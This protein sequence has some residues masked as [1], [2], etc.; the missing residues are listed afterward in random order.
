MPAD[1]EIAVPDQAPPGIYDETGRPRF[2]ADAGLDRLV[3]VVL[4]LTSEVW[5]LAERLDNLEQLAS[6]G[7]FVTY[8]QIKSYAPDA[9]E[10]ARRD[11]ER[12]RFVQSVLGPLREVRRAEK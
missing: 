7:G 1:E 10:T 3:S 8:E 11:A 5:V 4:Q 12:D 2:F 6:R 9:E